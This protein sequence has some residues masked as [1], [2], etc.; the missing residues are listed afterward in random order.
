MKPKLWP[1]TNDH[2][3]TTVDALM[4]MVESGDPE[5]VA[6]GAMLLIRM[7]RA[8]VMAEMEHRRFLATE[9]GR[10]MRLLEIARKLPEGDLYRIAQRHNLLPHGGNAD[11][12]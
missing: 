7:D 1:I 4:K 11:A 10:K 9:E 12:Q 8:N 3:Q 5:M 2:R 6:R